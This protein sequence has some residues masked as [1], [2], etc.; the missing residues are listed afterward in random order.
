MPLHTGKGRSVAR[1]LKDT[2]DYMENPLKTDYGEWVSSYECDVMTADAEFL[3]S[4]QRYAA[5]TGREQERGGVIAYHVRQSFSPGEVT[6]EEANRV[7][8]E[9]ALRF[10][11]GK[12][13]FIVCTHTDRDHIHS[14]IIWNSTALDHTKKFRN[15]IGSAFA[16]RRCSDLICAEHGLS[17]IKTPKPSKGKTYGKWLGDKRPLS[18]KQ[19]LRNS[20]DAALEQGPADFAEFLGLLRASGVTVDDS[21]KHLTFLAAPV[22]GLPD[23]AKPTRCDSLK[24]DYTVAAIMERIAGAR[25]VSSSAGREVTPVA[26]SQRPSLL[27][28]IQTKMQEGR[29]AGYERWAKLH[30]LK[31]MAQTLIYLQEQG[32]DDYALLRDRA[33]AASARFHSLS[34]RIRELDAGLAANAEMQ[35]QIVT[36]SKTRKTYVEYRKAG[37]SK[38]FKAQHE[39]DIILHQ[40]AKKYFDDLGYGQGRRLP[41]IASLR[42]AYAP[43]LEEKKRAH[44]EYRQ[45]RDDMRALVTARTNVDRLLNIDERQERERERAR[46]APEL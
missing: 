6:P 24:G 15:F 25:I 12:F 21:R 35:K 36:Y 42:S 23:Q 7:A 31:Q 29:G 45:A 3:L 18:F 41:T 9:L 1:A 28:D 30:N 34:D 11:K 17:V 5:L 32:L 2:V 13:S 38:R 44:R 37:Y 39:A 4:K 26:T 20:I 22:E 14:H 43:M 40:A 10:T 27:I 33:A 46:R 8:Y 19:R 16:L